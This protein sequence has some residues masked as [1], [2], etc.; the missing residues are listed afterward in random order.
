MK[1][2]PENKAK[3]RLYCIEEG[4]QR[5]GYTVLKKVSKANLT[6]KKE[7]SRKA[8]KCIIRE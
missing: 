8:N 2:D 3:K 4:L 6:I 1:A 5:K 7:L